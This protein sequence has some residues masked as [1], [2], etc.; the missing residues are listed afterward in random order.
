V[1]LSAEDRNKIIEIAQKFGATAVSLFGSYAKGN[2]KQG[3]DI[4]I[5]VEFEPGRSLFDL[6]RMERELSEKLGLE[7]DVVTPNSLHPRIRARIMEEK[8]SVL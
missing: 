1:H 3:S 7:V 2:A 6:V 4:D 8:V 5:L